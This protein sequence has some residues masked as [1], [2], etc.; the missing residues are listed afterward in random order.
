MKHGWFVTGTDTGVGKSRVSAG[1]VRLG[2]RQGRAAVGMKPVASGAVT[3]PDGLR[4][5]DALLLQQAANLP[6]PYEQVNPYLFVPP[7]APHIAAA[8]QGVDIRLETIQ[9]AFARLA[10]SADWVVVEGVGGW[11][12]PLSRHFALPDLAR[13]LG[14]PVILVVGMRLGCLNHALLTARAIQADGLMLAGWVANRV[15]AEFERCDANLATLEA[16]LDFP[17]LG[18]VPHTAAPAPDAV[19]DALAKGMDRIR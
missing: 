1:L 19:A 2:A 16:H 18:V 9:T 4:S 10:A 17:L 15:D 14:L 11:Q 8:E 12:V 7:I 6:V 5:E 3:T 13:A